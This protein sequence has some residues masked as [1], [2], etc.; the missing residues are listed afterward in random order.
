MKIKRD[1]DGEGGYIKAPTGKWVKVS[2]LAPV[3][4]RGSGRW[5]S[6]C[7]RSG[8]ISGRWKQDKESPNWLQRRRWRCDYEDGEVRA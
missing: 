1:A 5:S 2:S 8:K 4:R 7:S 6:Y 3:G